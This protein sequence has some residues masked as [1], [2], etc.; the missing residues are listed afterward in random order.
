M[1]PVRSFVLPLAVWEVVVLLSVALMY[2]LAGKTELGP[3]GRRYVTAA[4]ILGF[5]VVLLCW[6]VC[7]RVGRLAGALIGL[8]VGMVS[9]IVAGWFFGHLIDQSQYS[10]A[11]LW[12][13]LDAWVEGLQ[14]AIPSGVG[15]AIVGF[16][17]AGKTV[18]GVG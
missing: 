4:L 8:A 2:V 14:L 17:Q 11:H 7:R 1:S 6:S 18:H 13:F 15:G 16:L 12:T 5:I 9:P 10:W 3:E